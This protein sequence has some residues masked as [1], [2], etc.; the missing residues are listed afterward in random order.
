MSLVKKSLN[1]VAT[2]VTR[3]ALG[4][5]RGYLI[6]RELLRTMYKRMLLYLHKGHYQEKYQKSQILRFACTCLSGAP[7]LH[8]MPAVLEGIS[9]VFWAWFHQVQAHLPHAYDGHT[10]KLSQIFFSFFL[11]VLTK[12]NSIQGIFL[13]LHSGVYLVSLGP[14]GVGDR[15]QVSSVQGQCST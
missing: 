2:A 6:L 1:S 4:R 14:Y 11:Q 13:V 15:T 12:P 5:S 10:H 8:G 7:T 9:S 3:G